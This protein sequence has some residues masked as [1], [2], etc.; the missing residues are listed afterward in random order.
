MTEM[1]INPKPQRGPAPPARF[2][3]IT[4]SRDRTGEFRAARRHSVL[5]RVFRV[6]CPLGVLG[7]MSLYF[8]PSQL[9]VQVNG[10]EASV[11]NVTISDGGLK[12]VNPRIKGVHPKHG[13]Y[14]IRA[15]DAT[16]QIANPDLIT[17]NTVSGDLVSQEGETT[18]LQAPSGLFHSKKEELVF[19]NGLTIGGTAGFS[20][21]LQSGTAFFNDNR[22]VTT[23]PVALSF[24]KSTIKADGMTFYSADKRAIFEG[25]VRVH[26]QRQQGDSQ[27]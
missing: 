15:E 6:L 13:V 12:M 21:K 5:I 17:L 8:L 19:D 22:L 3:D 18:T 16:Q 14:D 25:N 2:E 10:G 24:R 1:A 20:G 7:V 23:D 26:L 9:T 4:E 27:Q 11:E